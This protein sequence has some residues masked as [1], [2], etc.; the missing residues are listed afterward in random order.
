VATNGFL[1]GKTIPK[2]QLSVHQ[3]N[4]LPY[5][6]KRSLTLELAVHFLTDKPVPKLK[7]NIKKSW[8]SLL[9]C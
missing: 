1:R 7:L 5:V 8:L 4:N 2:M 3:L 6:S 9:E